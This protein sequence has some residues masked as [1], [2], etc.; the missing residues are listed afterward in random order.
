M[1]LGVGLVDRAGGT[2]KHQQCIN[3]F[4]ACYLSKYVRPGLYI[5]LSL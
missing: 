3:N 5:W 4:V 1:I 2:Q